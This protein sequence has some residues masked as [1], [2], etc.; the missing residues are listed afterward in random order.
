MNN[1]ILT[2][3]SGSPRGGEKTWESLYKNV[4][5][6][7]NSDLA[8]CTTENYVL[9]KS[10]FE[11]ANYIWTLENYDN[12]ELYYEKNYEGN[13]KEYF[14]YGKGY[15]LYESGLIHFALKDF[16]RNNFM[17]IINKYDFI[18]FSR[19]DQFYIDKHPYLQNNKILIPKGEDYFGLCDRHAAFDSNLANKYFSIV[20]YINNAE[21]INE[22]PSFPNCESV[23]LKHLENNK[24]INNVERVDRFLFT[25]ALKSDKT[26]WRIPKY[27]IF[28]IKNLMIKY[29]DEFID[30]VKNAIKNYGLLKYAKDNFFIVFT[31]FYLK[32]RQIFRIRSRIE[33][34]KND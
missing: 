23:Y 12:F 6:H 16:I 26:N 20:D 33:D 22:I 2:I 29:P 5:E 15:G 14:E 21:S 9:S 19:Y 18:I 24:L 28:F 11:R 25:S 31:Y 1:K 27:K 4:L 8:L 7:L 34:N 32:L 30:G 17:E 10:L 3:L 13:W